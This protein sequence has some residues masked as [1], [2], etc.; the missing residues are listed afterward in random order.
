MQRKLDTDQKALEVNLNQ[1]IYGTFAEIGAGQEVARYFF[2]VGAA[3]GTIAKTM[4][5]Y[6]KT[7]SDCIYGDELTGRYVC[8]SRLYKMLDHEYELLIKRLSEK[9]P[10][11]LF[12]AFSDTI[13]ALNFH[14]TN[15]GH[16]WMGIRFQTR[17]G[18][19]A[20][21]LVVHARMMDNDP[22]LQ[23]KA[24]G[25]LG[26]NMVYACFYFLNDINQ[27]VKS[28]QD[29][30]KG[31]VV[32]DMIRISGPDFDHLDNRLLN[33]LLVQNG[34]ADVAMFSAEGDSLHASEKYYKRPTMVIRGT[35][36]PP[37]IVTEDVFSTSLKAFATAHQVEEEEVAML[38]EIN[39]LSLGKDLISAKEEFIERAEVLGA[40][41]YDTVITNSNNHKALINYLSEQKVDKLGIVLGIR[42]LLE[43]INERYYQN[44]DGNLLNAFG[45][46][47][48][49]RINLYT[50]PALQFGSNDIMNSK[51]LPVP[52]GIRHLYQ[53]LL[54]S[55]LIKDLED[56]NPEILHVMP[57][58]V[59]NM[60]R[61]NVGGWENY[62]PSVLVNVIKEK[63]L[64]GY[65]CQPMHFEY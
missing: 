61:N 37:T 20:N 30:L 7:Y 64:F 1:K 42:Q 51:N 27:F 50:Y 10:G 29:Y 3:A 55:E 40:L 31:R 45:D 56:Y 36:K 65:P 63:C 22:Q 49:K 53:F 24:I 14:R 43:L 21:D 5:A 41:G 34:L 48:T 18:G 57:E 58:E 25:I 15:I 46:L 47:F 11:S 39:T 62:I 4:S 44:Q 12:F 59:L 16:G 19:P 60:I 26:V 52:A 35:Y 38:A 54:E 17:E 6:D 23:A 28:L 9:R 32:I 13:S 8:E 33:Y 2:K